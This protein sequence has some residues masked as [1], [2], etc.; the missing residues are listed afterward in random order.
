[1]GTA[2]LVTGA[3]VVRREGPALAT[4]TSDTDPHAWHSP[5]R[6]TQRAVDQPHSL[7]R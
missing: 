2:A 4:A 6:P 3:A 7:Q 1:M 5:H